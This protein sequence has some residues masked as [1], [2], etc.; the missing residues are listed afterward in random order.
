M[1][2]HNNHIAVNAK[3]R[4]RNC[5]IEIYGDNN[6]VEIGEKVMIYEKAYISIKGNNCRICVGDETTI[7]SAKFFMEE[8][9]TSIVIGRD[10]MLGRD[11]C[12]Q[13]TDFHS[14]LDNVT[15][16]RINPPQ[17]VRI[18]D[19]VWLG[20]GVT[21]GKGGEVGSHSV[22][23]EKSLVTKSFTQE[24]VCIAGMPAKVL[25]ENIDWSREKL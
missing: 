1:K 2:G 17:N 7:G 8:S 18:G 6:Y 21:I 22:V 24:H 9:N 3:C 11:I 12:M 16:R 15:H 20:F 10:C 13:T 14:I 19:H 23:G 4:F 5:L 25:K